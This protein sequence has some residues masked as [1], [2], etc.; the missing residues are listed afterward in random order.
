[1][2]FVLFKGQS[3]YGSLR[4][5]IDQLAEALRQQEHDVRVVDLEPPERM[6]A[7]NAALADPPDCFFGIGGV[8]SDLRNA[9]GSVYDQLGAVYAT[10]Y[11]DHPV[12]H[13]PRITASIRRYVAFFLDR[14]HVQFLAGWPG[15][16]G[17]AV[18]SF[19]PPGANELPEPVDASDEAFAR[20]DIPL[21]FT[22]T[23]RGPPQPGWA[24]WEESPAKEVV[25][26]IAGRMA[27]DGALPIL[28]ALKASLA[29]RGGQL[30]PEL[31]DQFVPLL[32]P[33]QAF[34]EAY[35]RDALLHA[36]GRAG[37]PMHVYG[38]G[39]EALTALY[40]SFVYGG[41][42]SFEETMRLLR[43]TRLVLNTNNGF[44]A[45]GHE[46]VFTAMCAGAAVFS[47]ASK[48]YAEAFKE[49]RE[50]VTFPW[51][52][53]AGAPEQLL[54]LMDDTPRL[55]GIARGGHKRAM[56][57]HRWSD[58]ASKIVKAVKQAR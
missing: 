34:A 14:S 28:D 17:L 50:I 19:L 22:G 47:D 9:S 18:R 45:G 30:T 51:S 53:M 7:I 46:R 5:H 41:V 58:R 40:P 24:A 29:S 33:A 48:Y 13:V 4:L 21:L 6:A 15:A 35:H 11:V 12:H 32:Q 26:E 27:A 25:G 38:N 54:A 37:V 8:G 20:R 36:L 31:F 55:A 44:V 10:L 16:R 2:R 43:R 56:A 23:Y 39:W 3:Q 52:R 1:M 57:E 49:G 42:G